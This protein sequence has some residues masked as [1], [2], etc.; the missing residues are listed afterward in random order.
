MS[1]LQRAVMMGA[2]AAAMMIGSPRARAEHYL[3]ELSVESPRGTVQAPTDPDDEPDTYRPTPAAV[4][5][6]G[7]PLVLQFVMT[8]VYPHETRRDIGVHYWIRRQADDATPETIDTSAPSEDGDGATA[9]DAK[10]LPLDGRFVVNFKPKGMAGLRQ[11]L[12]LHDPGTYLL[13][14]QSEH[15]HSD[16]EHFSQLILHVH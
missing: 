7:E 1:A 9:A 10:E 16:H 14:V 8:N 11:K 2:V 6:H 15:S 12:R 3:I 5:Q 4:V 13:R